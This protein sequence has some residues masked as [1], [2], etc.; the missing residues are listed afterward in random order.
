M[1]RPIVPPL[2]RIQFVTG[3]KPVAVCV[4]GWLRAGR[5]EGEGL[6]VAQRWLRKAIEGCRAHGHWV[7]DEAAVRDAKGRAVALSCDFAGRWGITY[8]LARGRWSME[9]ADQ[10][11]ERA[12]GERRYRFN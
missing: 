12:V 7:S 5:R 6:A 8:D 3:S 9:T 10:W 2:H 11:R 4:H 1:T